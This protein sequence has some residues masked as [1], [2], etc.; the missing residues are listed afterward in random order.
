MQRLRDMLGRRAPLALIL[1]AVA[2]AAVL[3]VLA[4]RWTSGQ[5]T[6]PDDQLPI[7]EVTTRTAQSPAGAPSRRAPREAVPARSEPPAA[8]HRRAPDPAPTA[9]DDGERRDDRPSDVGSDDDDD[10][11][12]DSRADD[13]G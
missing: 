11:D 8:P 3:S 7:V 2:V 5:A 12:D 4:G 10:D 1:S 9:P 13:D 6:I